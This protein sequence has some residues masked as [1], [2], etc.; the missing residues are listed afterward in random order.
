MSIQ[1]KRFRSS[2]SS[3]CKRLDPIFKD[4]QDK[5]TGD[6]IF[7]E[8]DVNIHKTECKIYDV[9]GLPFVVIEH[10]GKKLV[11]I[12]G[13]YEYAHYEQEMTKAIHYDKSSEKTSL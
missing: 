6:V 2:G 8:F 7:Y 4:L 5:F 11:Q 10:N 13:F 1:V 12:S 3:P 9:R